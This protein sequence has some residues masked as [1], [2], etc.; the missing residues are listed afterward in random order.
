M[1]PSPT[2]HRIALAIALIGVAVS[3]Y[4]WFV[5]H[6]LATDAGYTSF[7]NLGGVVDCDA[8]LQ[9]R[10]GT[11]LEVPVSVWGIVGFAAGALLALPGALG[12]Q[13]PLADL[14][15]LGLVSASLGFALVL[16]GIATFVLGHACV[17]CLTLDAV[18]VAWF[19]AAVPLAAR[20][21]PMASGPW[22]SRRTAAYGVT[23]AGLL[24]AVAGGTLAAVREPGAAHTLDDVRSR[25]AEFVDF[26]LKLPVLSQDELGDPASPAK[27]AADAA[28]TIVEFSDFECPACRH[29]FADLRDLTRTHPEVRVVFRNYPLDS[30]CNPSVSRAVHPNA[31]LAAAAAECAN[32]AGRFWEY[33]DVLFENQ[34]QLD[35]QS[36]LRHARELGLPLDAFRTC[37]DDPATMARVRHDIQAGDRVGVESTPTLFINGRR[38]QGAL[39]PPYYA[40]AL[41]IERHAADTREPPADPS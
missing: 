22:L 31:C 19:V 38:L 24:L 1:A 5:G 7:C 2:R 6:Q 3:A 8:V 28:V 23:A 17:L 37:L 20:F 18:I 11:F 39:E 27:G 29:A 4:T 21:Q 10:Y 32:R 41:I 40:Y 25:D 30:S 12:V 15:L 35:R 33:H 16:L 34:Q 9:S 26:Y 13:S 36:L 14:L